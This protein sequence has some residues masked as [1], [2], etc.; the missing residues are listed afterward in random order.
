VQAAQGIQRRCIWAVIANA[1]EISVEIHGYSLKRS[2]EC[3]V[4][5]AE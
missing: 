4:L 2:A 3:W 1:P 5:S